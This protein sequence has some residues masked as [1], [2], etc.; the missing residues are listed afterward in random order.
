MHKWLASLA[1]ISFAPEVRKVTPKEIPR[2]DQTLDFDSSSKH[3]WF[4]GEDVFQNLAPTSCNTRD[5]DSANDFLFHPVKCFV[6]FLTSCELS[7]LN[8]L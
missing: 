8:E 4:E 7:K 5:S 3:G 6:E 2:T 1:P